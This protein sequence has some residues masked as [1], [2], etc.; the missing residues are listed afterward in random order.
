[1]A[2]IVDRGLQGNSAWPEQIAGLAFNPVSGWAENLHRAR[3]ARLQK[4][5]PATLSSVDFPHP[6]GPQ[7]R[8][9]SPWADGKAGP[10]PRLCRPDPGHANPTVA[11][12]GR[13]PRAL[14]YPPM[15]SPQDLD[16][17]P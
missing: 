6:S 9:N 11:S 12:Q 17:M 4:A 15:F 8:T 16:A 1:M 3:G 2:T 5:R 13:L 7:W 14:P 10:T